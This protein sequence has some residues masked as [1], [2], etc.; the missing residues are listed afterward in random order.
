VATAVAGGAWET[1]REQT[2][3]NPVAVGTAAFVLGVLIGR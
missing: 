2:R 1:L 3:R